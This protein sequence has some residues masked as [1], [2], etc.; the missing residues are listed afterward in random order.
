MFLSRLAG[1]DATEVSGSAAAARR[2]WSVAHARAKKECAKSE[3]FIDIA[4]AKA[5][6]LAHH[7]VS[8]N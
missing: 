1:I 8:S 6:M 4:K 2:A 7:L 5:K 3:I